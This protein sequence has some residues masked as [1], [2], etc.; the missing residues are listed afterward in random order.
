MHSHYF[1]VKYVFLKPDRDYSESAAQQT[2]HCTLRV[3]P[4]F[5]MHVNIVNSPS[6]SD[7]LEHNKYADAPMDVTL[8]GQF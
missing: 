6:T 1:G 2:L 7:I 3:G 8:A 5:L 4:I